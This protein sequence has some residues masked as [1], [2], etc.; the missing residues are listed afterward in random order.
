M[1]LFQFIA[2]KGSLASDET[3]DQIVRGVWTEDDASLDLAE[4]ASQA[5]AKGQS[6]AF[7]TAIVDDAAVDWIATRGF[8]EDNPELR[9]IKLYPGSVLGECKINGL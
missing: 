9:Q 8:R 5:R 4:L 6:P 7:V 2:V 3:A 1:R